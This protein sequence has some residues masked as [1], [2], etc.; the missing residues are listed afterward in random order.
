VIT[1]GFSR[2]FAASFALLAIV[3][4]VHAVSTARRTQAELRAQLEQQALAL[5]DAVEAGSRNAVRS[6]ALVEQM[7]GERL[8]DNAR[9]IDALLLRPM[10][11]G[12]LDQIT[13]RNRLRRVD[14]L[15]LDG[16][17]WTPP[18]PPGPM[19]RGDGPP[20]EPPMMRGDGPPG[21]RPMK[22]FM[23]G[24]RWRHM[25][26]SGEPAEGGGAPGHAPPTSAGAP[27]RHAPFP[28]AL[29]PVPPAI[30]D[31]RFWEGSVFGVAIGATS[32][33]GIVAVHADAAY[34]LDFRREM[35]VDRQLGEVARQAGVMD[36]RVI[37]PDATVLADADG[38]RVGQ[39]LD[40]ATLVA[41][42]ARPAV[43]TRL[44]D[45]GDGRD[46]RFEVARPIALDDGRTALLAIGLS[47]EP[48]ARAWRRDLRAGSLLAGA[49]LLLGGAGL[50]AIF[51][52]QRRHLA[53]VRRLE[54]EMERRDRL[55]V[56]G[57]V[58]A[59]F[60]HEVRNPLN[61][62]SM[63]LQR[64]RAEFA[65]APVEEYNRFVDL[66]QSEVRRLNG[67]VEEFIALARPVA[68]KPA[69]FAADD[70]LQEL[71]ALLEGEARAAEVTVNVVAPGPLTLV[72]DRDQIKQVLFNLALNG[73]QAMRDGGVLTL[74][75]Q[76]AGAGV[77]LSVD[78]TGPGIAPEA[79]GR[80]FDP[81]FT[82][83][84]DGLGLGLT[85]ARRIAEAHDGTIEVEASDA[86]G[87]RFAVTLPGAGA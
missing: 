15:D 46:A 51:W 52:A 60:A 85:I 70:L 69:A 72:A 20:G 1:R 43:A 86:R 53:E 45:G 54:A 58:A 13:A 39:R 66:M 75:A 25:H 19:M 18:E 27:P 41:L 30:Q 8:L 74:G 23:W 22:T 81:Y 78:D 9:L 40:D 16:R 44:V 57:D 24:R 10:P 7:I 65:P 82:T 61:A 38:A 80:I 62:V 32:F 3:V 11:P 56:V 71:R 31:R 50:G 5:A 29:T 14:L 68:I 83:R 36:V 55:A 59:A 48:M 73:L 79:R 63:G 67:I 28:P 77:R 4:G 35:G 76:R 47:T 34:V 12:L 2:Y 6:N 84:R 26:D 42:A 33:R 37:G 87:T 21:E 49:V 17:P 64:L